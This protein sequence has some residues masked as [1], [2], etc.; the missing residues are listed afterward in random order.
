MLLFL[1]VFAD[2]S[3]AE[4]FRYH[5]ELDETP[6]GQKY[7]YEIQSVFQSDVVDIVNVSLCI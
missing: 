5:W 4:I 6:S 1:T 7:C 2:M 3:I